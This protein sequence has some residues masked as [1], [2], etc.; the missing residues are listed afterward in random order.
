MKKIRFIAFLVIGL[1]SFF[2]TSSANAQTTYNGLSKTGE[3]FVYYSFDSVYG[4]GTGEF[5]VGHYKIEL[6][7]E[8]QFDSSS[9]KFKMLTASLKSQFGLRASCINDCKT[10]QLKV[11]KVSRRSPIN[12]ADWYL[13]DLEKVV[14]TYF[15]A[16]MR[17][18]DK[19]ASYAGPWEFSDG[20]IKSSLRY[21]NNI[22]DV[23]AFIDQKV[24]KTEYLYV[25]VYFYENNLLPPVVQT[26]SV[27]MDGK[28]AVVEA[29]RWSGPSIGGKSKM[30]FDRRNFWTLYYQKYA[31]D[32]EPQ[33][34]KYFISGEVSNAL[35]VESKR[36]ITSTNSGVLLYSP[37][38]TF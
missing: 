22:V 28:K 26:F 29:V 7:G 25:E 31:A 16:T 38:G 23:N 36:K 24:D 30:S 20:I 18:A 35:E 11:E 3:K 13:P 2:G 8:S 6:F 1:V 19:Y 27:H 37:T 32:M 5:Q 12:G 21:G 9:P 34:M 10:L 33:F 17:Q 4:T 15:D 14:G